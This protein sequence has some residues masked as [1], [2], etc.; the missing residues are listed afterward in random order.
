[1]TY[2]FDDEKKFFAFNQGSRDLMKIDETSVSGW[3]GPLVR[4]NLLCP[5][6]RIQARKNRSWINSIAALSSTLGK[7]KATK[8]SSRYLQ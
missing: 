2:E 3:Y 4:A 8:A 1:M 5:H 6:M 7:V